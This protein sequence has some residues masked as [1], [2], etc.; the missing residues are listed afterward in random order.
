[1]RHPDA[2]AKGMTVILAIDHWFATGRHRAPWRNGRNSPSEP[3]ADAEFAG[4]ERHRRQAHSA[5]LVIRLVVRRVLRS[6]R[7][8]GVF[9]SALTGVNLPGARDLLLRVGD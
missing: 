7:D 5:V 6:L 9:A 3:R 1:M 4:G 2:S 8:R